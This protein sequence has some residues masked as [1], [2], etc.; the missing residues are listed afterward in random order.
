VTLATWEQQK[1]TT[2]I[3]DRNIQN[4]QVSL[5]NPHS[6]TNDNQ[7]STI[8]TSIVIVNYNGGEL[9]KK[10]VE[11]L[12]STI[13]PD[14]EIILVDNVSQDGSA[15]LIEYHFPQVSLIR[16]PKNLGFGG[17]N[18]LGVQHARG[19]Y[20]AFINPDTLAEPG[21]LEALINSLET[22]PAA[23]MATPRIVLMHDPT[24]IN[25]CGNDIHYTGL[26]LCRGMNEDR[27]HY[28]TPAEVS[29]ISGA[30]FVMRRDL[31]L[32]LGAFDEG[33]FLY[34]ED[35]DLSLRTR[36]AG[37]RCLYVPDAIIHHKYQLRFGPRK[38]YYQELG[39]YRMLL[40]HFRWTTLLA[41]TPAL[42]TA[43]AITWGFV[44]IQDHFRIMN[45]LRAYYAVIQTWKDMMQQRRQ[46][47]N[48]RQVTDY[49]ILRGNGSSLDFGQT[50]T[51]VV[52]RLANNIVNPWFGLWRKHIL[53]IIKPDSRLPRLQRSKS[54][55]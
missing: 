21:W 27:E 32:H 15:D 20:I 47:Q 19:H 50:G 23:G 24:K 45:K 13:Q 6:E 40:K 2:T 55:C 10:C 14:D 51:S 11:S 22:T 44:L 29:A 52:V 42:I 30:A 1:T 33:Y 35:T 39:R 4:C 17:G 48:L 34:M 54:E 5:S 41:L 49:E 28:A 53:R 18:N 25:T 43:E 37:Y 7:P 8:R 16:S 31:F 36:L 12:L 26:T 3:P 38:T 9:L 46:V